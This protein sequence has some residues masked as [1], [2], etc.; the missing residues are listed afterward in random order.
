V[1]TSQKRGRTSYSSP[2][3]SHAR[4]TCCCFASGGGLLEE[5]PDKSMPTLVFAGRVGLLVNDLMQQIHNTAHL[6]GKLEIIQEWRMLP[7]DFPPF[8]TVQRYFYGGRLEGRWQ[9]Y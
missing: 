4:I 7:S 3:W 2:P 6:D 5:L 1:V 8:T 9:T